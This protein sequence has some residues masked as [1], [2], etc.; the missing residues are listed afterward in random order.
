M[1]GY[2]YG[3]HTQ[4]RPKSKGHRKS[5]T[6]IVGQLTGGADANDGAVRTIP[7]VGL[8]VYLTGCQGRVPEGEFEADV[9]ASSAADNQQN[10]AKR[11]TA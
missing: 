11:H 5:S 6:I 8:A 10:A 1:S 2:R 7:H 3:L 9:K 4:C